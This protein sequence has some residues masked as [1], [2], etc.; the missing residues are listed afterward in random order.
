M[1]SETLREKYKHGMIWAACFATF[2]PMFITLY[3]VTKH[4]DFI[5]KLPDVHK[6]PGVILQEPSKSAE[7]LVVRAKSD[8]PKGAEIDEQMLELVWVPGETNFGPLV[9]NLSD[10][11]GRKA[12]E[13][14][15][16]GRLIRAAQITASAR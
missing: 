11:V 9:R 7:S 13:A 14:I 5:I 16:R 12:G 15:V 2:T 10:V 3:V 1:D 6:R 8:I 4:P